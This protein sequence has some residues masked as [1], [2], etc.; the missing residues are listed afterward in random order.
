MF[1]NFLHAIT[2]F[3]LII[4]SRLHWVCLL[5][6]VYLWLLFIFLMLGNDFISATIV[7]FWHFHW[8]GSSLFLAF[9]LFWL[10]YRF[11]MFSFPLLS[12][13]YR[14]LLLNSTKFEQKTMWSIDWHLKLVVDNFYL[15]F[16]FCF[17]KLPH[18]FK[19]FNEKTVWP[20]FCTTFQ[21]SYYFSFAF[22]L[23]SLGY[24]PQYSYG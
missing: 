11:E 7:C 15:W 9:L 22:L 17:I 13:F 2:R 16:L 12:I 5:F 8:N 10:S 24:W 4:I 19:N 18:F 1:H 6:D 21:L 3:Q 14:P 23:L 20:I